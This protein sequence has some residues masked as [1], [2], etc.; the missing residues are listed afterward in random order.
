M[1]Q[2]YLRFALRNLWL[3]K[4]QTAILV[5]GLA[6]GLAT[7]FFISLWVMS[8]LS[9][10]S[11]HERSQRIYRITEKVWTDGSGEYCASAP[12]ALG[13]T[14]LR[15]LP[16]LLENQTR[17][18]QL[19]SSSYTLENGAERRFNEAKLYFA[20]PG[21]FNMFSFKLKTGDPITCLQQPNCV[22]L[23]ESASKKYFG[24]ADPMGKI[25]RFEG[26]KDLTVTGLAAETP[27]ESHLHFDVLVSFSTL[28]NMLTDRQKNGFYWNPAWTYVLLK[29]NVP[30]SQLEAALPG[31]V[32]KF[33][34]ETIRNGTTLPIQ[35]LCDIHLHSTGLVGEFEPNGNQA[36]VR[37]FAT[38]AIFVL[39]IAIINFINLCTAQSIRRMKEIGLR[40]TLGAG[41]TSLIVQMLG[42]ALLTSFFAGLVAVVLMAIAL[43]FF[44]DLTSKSFALHHFWQY[45]GW[46][47]TGT[48][49]TGLLAGAYPAFYLSGFRPAM[50]VKGGRGGGFRSRTQQ[51]LVVVQFAISVALI[52][53]TL[54]ASRQ[55]KYL[56]EARLGF[57]RSG[58]LILPVSRCA[59]ATIDKFDDFRRQLLQNPLIQ[60][61]TAL[62]E[63][64]G[65]RFNTGTYNPEGI[66]A[67]KQFARLY[68]RDG[69]L[70]TFGIELASGR[71]FSENRLA[72][73][74]SVII[75]EAMVRHLGWGTAEN[76]LQ[77]RLNKQRVVGVAK[78]FHFASLH[79]AIEPLVLHVPFNNWQNGFFVQ[80]MAVRVAQKDMPSA[81]Q[82]LQKTWEQQVPDRAFEYSFLDDNHAKLYQSEARLGQVALIFNVL[83]LLIA[84]MGLVGL[85]TYL[86]GQ[87]T[88]EIGVRKVLGA[89]VA[90]ITRLLASDFLKLVLIA[91]FIASPVA[92]YFMQRWLADFA[93]RIDIQWWMFVVAALAAVFVAILTVG[94]QSIR[95]A[96][97]NP[98][99]SLRSE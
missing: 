78:D 70:E 18:M 29:D 68:V 25:L 12:I 37:V 90:S 17:L 44:N 84:C 51:A 67:E 41:R 77:K 35:A 19:R 14:L 32:Q 85:A 95:A 15:E 76:A 40:K 7:C 61:V 58:V 33:F 91:I 88:K 20:E 92:Y 75:N 71:S 8:E 98:V 34:P 1:Y 2:N 9:Y 6:L 49:L 52:I 45:G 66:D 55:F 42:E 3:Q 93:Y 63:P 24:S 87:R 73:S 83:S 36:Y 60:N 69:F 94:I 46:F 59:L 47:L 21:V 26:N 65:I 43:P 53:A 4:N 16:H 5:S 97:A 96:L 10:D 13:P 56:R 39:L 89:S 11:F 72:D 99:E 30:P 23:T 62:E 38:V 54:V 57:D 74:S 81:I 50:A 22:V 86:L 48:M 27:V 80:Y 64:L 82:F 28:D 79:T 31:I